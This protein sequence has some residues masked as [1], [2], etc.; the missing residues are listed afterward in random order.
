ML[1]TRMATKRTL[2]TRSQADW[3]TY[4]RA[5]GGL[6]RPLEA[7]GPVHLFAAAGGTDYASPV[8]PGL[9][10]PYHQHLF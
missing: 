4:L 7:L 10:A 5:R 8:A 6:R 9:T 3:T 1:S 2:S